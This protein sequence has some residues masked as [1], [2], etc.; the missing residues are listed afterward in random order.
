MNKQNLDSDLTYKL[1]SLKNI[2]TAFVGHV[3][4]LISK[5][6]TCIFNSDKFEKIFCLKDQLTVIFDRLKAVDNKFISLNENA[7]DI[8]STNEIYFEQNSRV[9]NTNKIIENCISLKRP[10]AESLSSRSIR[11]SKSRV[12]SNSSQSQ[13]NISSSSSVSRKRVKA[14]LLLK[15]S[16]ERFERKSKILERQKSLELELE[17][18]NI[19]E[20]ENQLKLLELKDD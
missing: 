13:S 10:F 7:E 9:L 14:E 19:I 2:R 16:H 4:R 8:E 11:S 18:E 1:L 20:A 5:I 3:T 12:N 15:Q 6:E 17:R